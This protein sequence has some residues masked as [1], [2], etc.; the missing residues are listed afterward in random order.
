MPRHRRRRGRP[1]ARCAPRLRIETRS[2]AVGR[3][4]D[5]RSE[6][7]F[8]SSVCDAGGRGLVDET[9][10]PEALGGERSVD[11]MRLVLR[12]GVG[13]QMAGARRRLEAASAPSAVR[14][15]ARNG[16]FSDK[17]GTIGRHVNNPTP[18]AQHAQATKNREK[19]ADRLD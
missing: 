16:G 15:E 14:V 4:R 9:S 8:W 1:A 7:N 11:R 2:P 3:S 6:A 17:G 13:E 5:M 12:D 18:V 19:L 10:G